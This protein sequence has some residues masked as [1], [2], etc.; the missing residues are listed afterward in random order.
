MTTGQKNLLK[1]YGE[2]V[3]RKAYAMHEEGMGG[4][5]VGYILG[6]KTNT[7]DA[8]IDIGRKLSQ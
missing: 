5:T 6:F 8:L 7:A 2:D 1:K 4:Y 3:C